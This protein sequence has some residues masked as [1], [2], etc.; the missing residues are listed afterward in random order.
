MGLASCSTSLGYKPEYVASGVSAPV[1]QGRAVIVMD[2]AARSQTFSGGPQSMT[3]GA[4]T[5]SV[6]LGQYIEK[7]SEKVCA[8][9]FSQGAVVGKAAQDGAYALVVETQ[10]F[11]YKYDQLSSLGFAITPKVTVALKVGVNGPKGE[12]IVPSRRYERTDFTA[13][14]AYV[15]SANP[16]EKINQSAHMAIADILR[17]AMG[18]LPATASPR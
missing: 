12:V 3:G 11:S 8:P 2:D 17:E 14:G 5:I 13:T 6:P 7:I 1:V 9:Y 18:Q 16:P 4:T 10:G 15:F